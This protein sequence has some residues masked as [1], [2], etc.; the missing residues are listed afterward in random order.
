M[1]NYNIF[2]KRTAAVILAVSVGLPLFSI[3]AFSQTS[4]QPS[5]EEVWDSIESNFFIVYFRP[6]ANLNGIERELNNR[7]IY[8]DQPARYGEVTVPDEICYRLDRLFGRVKEILNMYPDIPKINIKIYRD[9]EELNNE[10]NK[11]L[12]KK[13]DIGSFYIKDHNT[14]YTSEGDISDS[15]ITHEMAHAIIDHYFAVIPPEKVSEII[16]SYVDIHLED[17]SPTE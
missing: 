13:A 9:R 11:L 3:V 1:C 15:V 17:A 6:D 16:A 4:D 12:G 2:L 8:Y 14:I 7:T 5:N 10:Y